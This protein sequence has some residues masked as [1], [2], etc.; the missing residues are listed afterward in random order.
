MRQAVIGL[1]LGLALAAAFPLVR[2]GHSEEKDPA[3]PDVAGEWTGTWAL[4]GKSEKAYQMRLD[5]RVAA[6]R[7]GKW[8]A[9]FEGEC[10]RPYKYTVKMLGRQ[11]GKSVLFKGTADLG[12]DDGGVY[13]WIGRATEDEFLGFYTSEGHTGT[14]RL[15]RPKAAAKALSQQE[16]P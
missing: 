7:G 11:A 3:P 14:F 12:K 6:Q 8:Q 16:Q 9:T 1:T 10:G 5:A 2:A 15:T 4:A 13:D